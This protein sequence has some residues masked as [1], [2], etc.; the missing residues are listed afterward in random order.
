MKMKLSD[1]SKKEQV[2]IVKKNLLVYAR[3]LFLNP[4]NI[5]QYIN[6]N[7]ISTTD[8]FVLLECLNKYN[9][10]NC[11]CCKKFNEYDFMSNIMSEYDKIS[12]LIDIVQDNLSK[13]AW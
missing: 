9:V 13:E 8:A 3:S 11:I 4:H 12:A 7:L 10:S 5:K 6:N 2:S 1:F